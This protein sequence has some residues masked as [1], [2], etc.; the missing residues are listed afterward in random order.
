[1][2][3]GIWIVGGL[4]LGFG[5][6]MMIGGFG[7]TGIGLGAGEDILPA[8]ISYKSYGYDASLDVGLTSS[9]KVGLPL[10]VIGIALLVFANNSAWKDTNNEY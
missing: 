9:G 7:P 10:I 1:M 2:K 6:V 3:T 4:C 5:A 8:A